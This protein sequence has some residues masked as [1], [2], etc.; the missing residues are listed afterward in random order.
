LFNKIFDLFEVEHVDVATI[1]KKYRQE[2]FTLNMCF[3]LACVTLYPKGQH[4]KH[5]FGYFMAALQAFSPAGFGFDTIQDI[6]NFLLIA[7]FGIFQFIGILPSALN[8]FRLLNFPRLLGVGAFP[9]LPQDLSRIKNA[10]EEPYNFF[11]YLN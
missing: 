2:L 4:N 7:R 6:R 9:N 1:S 3:A 5:P 10:E 11:A 8:F